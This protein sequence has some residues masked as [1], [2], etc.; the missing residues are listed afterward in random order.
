MVQV[1]VESENGWRPARAGADLCV[2]VTVPGS[3]VSLQLQKG[4]PAK[5]LAAFAADYNAFVEPLRDP[6]S[7]SWTPT[8]SVATSNH[9]NAT[10]MD[11]N[12]NSHP[13][14]VRGT[15]TAAQAKTIREL[16]AFYEDTVFWAGD[17]T[18]PIDEMHWQMGYG[19]WN[20][21]K[22]AS[23]A[24]RKIRS[25]GFSTFRRGVVEAKPKDDVS[26]L[27]PAQPP[28]GWTVADQAEIRDKVRQ[29][30]GA[31]FNPVP[32]KSRYANP[33]DLWSTK[34]LI[35]NDDGFIFD[36]ITE[37]DAA[38]GDQTAIN[39]IRQAAANGDVIAQSAL[40]N[41]S[42]LSSVPSSIAVQSPSVISS[43][44][45]EPTFVTVNDV[46]CWNCGKQYPSELP[47]CPFCNVLQQMPAQEPTQTQEIAE[48]VPEVLPQGRHM[49]P[50]ADN[51][52]TTF[53]GLPA[54]NK[55]VVEQLSLL[56]RF[57]NELPAEVSSAIDKLIPVL[58][59]LL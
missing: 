33:K 24:S 13:F 10:A 32:S 16:L 36:L 25:D 27:P 7:A 48:I 40:H 3:K 5:I 52:S 20:N 50:E 18:D 1:G 28:V 42:S 38:L 6:D 54:V 31:L 49:A 41:L 14:R 44:P 23:F 12:W 30:W 51:N 15:F 53:T 17:W 9:L 58:K 4:L 39:R 46:T 29:I 43:S 47:Q 56:Q 57:S 2:W 8:N 11:L 45:L 59:G 37:H 19:S 55:S 21:P 35:R 26:Q 34:D 22:T